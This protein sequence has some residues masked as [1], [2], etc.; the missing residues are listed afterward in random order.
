MYARL[1]R[2]PIKP[3][4]DIAPVRALRDSVV[5]F[6]VLRGGVAEVQ[7]RE[8]RLRLPRP[9]AWRYVRGFEPLSMEWLDAAL[10]PGMTVA[11]V[12]AHV[13]F[14][15]LFM[16]R[17]VGAD[18]TVH[19]FEPVDEN[20]RYIRH[21]VAANSASNIIIHPFAL[22]SEDGVRPFVVTNIS[23]SQGFYPHPLAP[24]S[25]VIEVRQAA[26]DGQ[27]TRL[28]LAK[29]DVEGAEL[30]VLEGMRR[31]LE[32][33]PSMLVEWAPASQLSAGHQPNEL[34]ENLVALGYKLRVLD[35]FYGCERAPQ[36]VLTLLN[37]HELPDQ[38]YANLAC[39]PW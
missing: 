23:D 26:L 20:L 21:N 15:G 3:L 2:T 22:G 14:V 38:W 4:F 37:A 16:A 10:R 25:G 32:S 24:S 13:G 6:R 28:D 1:L 12:G 9:F 5:P 18:G 27:I 30:D 33:H 31:L 35:D 36:D 7:V 11:D 8:I 29:I 39:E 17:R 19:C 34:V